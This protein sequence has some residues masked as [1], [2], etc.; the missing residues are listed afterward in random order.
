MLIFFLYTG[1]ELG[2]GLWIY[3]LLTES[4]GVAPEVAGVVTGSYWAMFTLGRILAG[5]YV[6]K[7]L[8]VN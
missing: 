5:V 8:A 4:R 6:K 2:L 1:I 3:S 7:L